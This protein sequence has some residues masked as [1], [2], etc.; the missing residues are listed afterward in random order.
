MAKINLVQCTSGYDNGSSIP[1]MQVSLQDWIQVLTIKKG[2]AITLLHL[3]M[4]NVG[5][6]RAKLS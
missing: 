3:F 5:R 6:G 4:A 1:N 2:L